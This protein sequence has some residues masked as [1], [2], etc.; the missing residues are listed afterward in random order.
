M[1][2]GLIQADAQ[3]QKGRFN[4]FPYWLDLVALTVAE[5]LTVYLQLL[6][7]VVCH[8]VLLTVFV[9][10]AA[11]A[12]DRAQRNLFMVL[13]LAPLIRILSLSMPLAPIP[14]IYWYLLIYGPLLAATIMVMINTGLAPR[15][16]GLVGTGWPLQIV[17]G[18]VIGLGLGVMEYVILRPVPLATSFTLIGVLVPSLILTIT[19]GFGE[20]LL[21]RG[22]MQT[23]A[24]RVMGLWSVLYVSLVFAVLHIGHYSIIDVVFVFLVALL[25]TAMVKKSGSLLGVTLAHGIA[26]SMLYCVM[27]FI[28]S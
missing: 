4:L 21:F 14:Q 1:T 11:L 23:L 5:V 24:D 27:P 9:V 18:I 15:D 17:L 20:E 6:A 16:V 19:T 7:G 2:D 12:P 8:G 26:N 13:C 10:Q 3:L 25:F 28:L 22:V